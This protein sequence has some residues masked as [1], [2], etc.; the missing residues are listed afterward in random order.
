MTSRA[1]NTDDETGVRNKPSGR[2]LWHHPV[3][4]TLD[5]RRRSQVA[6][7]GGHKARSA[8]ATT[9]AQRVPDFPPFLPLGPET[10][11]GGK[12]V[13]ER[14]VP[15]ISGALESTWFRG[16]PSL[17]RVSRVPRGA[18]EDLVKTVLRGDYYNV[19]ENGFSTI[20]EDGTMPA[21]NKDSSVFMPGV[22]APMTKLQERSFFRTQQH[23][24][25]NRSLMSRLIKNEFQASET[26]TKSQ[27]KINNII[28]R[29]RRNASQ[30]AS[31]SQSAMDHRTFLKQ[32]ILLNGR[33]SKR[34]AAGQIALEFAEL[35][36]PKATNEVVDFLSRTSQENRKSFE[37]LLG[38][39]R[40]T[41]KQ[42][43][44]AE[45]AP[46]HQNR[47]AGMMDNLPGTSQRPVMD[48]AM[49]LSERDNTAR[50]PDLGYT[51]YKSA[52]PR[53]GTPSLGPTTLLQ[54]RMKGHKPVTEYDNP[55]AQSKV[56]Y[57]ATAEERVRDLRKQL[58][59]RIY[60][61][62]PNKLAAWRWFD[63]NA[64]GYFDHHTLWYIAQEFM[65]DCTLEECAALHRLLDIDGDGL[66]GFVDFN[67]SIFDTAIHERDIF[68]VTA[69]PCVDLANDP[70]LFIDSD[71]TNGN[72]T[73]AYDWQRQTETPNFQKKVSSRPGTGA[74]QHRPG[75]AAT[76]VFEYSAPHAPPG[77]IPGAPTR[78]STSLGVKSMRKETEH[79][80]KQYNQIWADAARISA[81]AGGKDSVD[82]IKRLF[83]TVGPKSTPMGMP[84]QRV[85]NCEP[86]R[87][88]SR[89]KSSSG[90]EVQPPLKY[91][92]SMVP[93]GI[94]AEQARQLMRQNT[95]TQEA[96]IPAHKVT[97][98][99]SR[100]LKLQKGQ[101]IVEK[102]HAPMNRE[103]VV[104]AQPSL[105]RSQATAHASPKASVG[106][107]RSR[108][109]EGGGRQSQTLTVHAH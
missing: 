44:S 4:T 73:A 29:N 7:A 94:T 80:Q 109:I 57:R 86:A 31:R 63:P 91:D 40:S 37:D 82:S 104:V 2:V 26:K 89:M 79:I 81:L 68:N 17:Q 32:G 14:P 107:E 55:Y 8:V 60:I 97:S 34:Q 77:K 62:A 47:G 50:V 41:A 69:K 71:V 66:V 102:S 85:A 35:F 103:P 13:P 33:P 101:G 25:L 74:N 84:S 72:S 46:V 108:I 21:A 36:D 23:D 10:A 49:D 95:Q 5:P 92:S 6:V 100:K 70:I 105:A 22:K 30:P 15:E 12:L 38:S 99:L 87:P 76:E 48:A 56:D 67:Q 106:A 90:R 1:V 78:P 51:I 16:N 61:K 88:K 83:D 9:M 19:R 43:Q 65:I 54:D 75:T 42:P 39:I 98:S 58:R 24:Q 28:S 11:V 93:R 53:L 96:N 64:M 20:K 3:P 45:G 52:V 27:L 59:D 18:K